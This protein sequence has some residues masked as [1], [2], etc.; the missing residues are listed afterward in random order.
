MNEVNN[1]SEEVKKKNHKMLWIMVAVFGLPY[2]VA[3]YFYF[4]KGDYDFAK[5]NYGTIISP[6][7]PVPDFNLMKID[8]SQFKLSSLKGKWVLFSIGKSSCE[9][10]CVDNLYKIRQIKKA[11]GQN[12]KR[13]AKAFFLTDKENIESFKSLLKE[14]PG[15]DVIIPSGSEYSNYLLNFQHEGIELEDGMFIIDPMGNYMMAYPKGAEASKI[16]DD[17][18]RLLRVSKVG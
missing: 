7:R 10:D 6:A 14:Y 1:S 9:K 17:I 15:M 16:L 3:F 18:E 5:T 8:N 12:H 13:I 11:V 2:L 4:N